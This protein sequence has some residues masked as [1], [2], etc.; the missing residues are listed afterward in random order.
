MEL[1]IGNILQ[2][3][4]LALILYFTGYVVPLIQSLAR[5]R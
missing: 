2:G 3:F 4:A 1:I 5:W